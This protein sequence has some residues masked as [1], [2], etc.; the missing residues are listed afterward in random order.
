MEL[1]TYEILLDPMRKGTLPITVEGFLESRLS[2]EQRTK[3][4]CA[5]RGDNL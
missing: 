4:A 1:E 2:Q 5:I 3:L